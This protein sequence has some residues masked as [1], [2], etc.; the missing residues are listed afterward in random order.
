VAA[1]T[2]DHLSTV[3]SIAVL[4]FMAVRLVTGVRV[5]RSRSGRR[6]VSAVRQRIGWRHLWPVPVVLALVVLVAST[7]MA[8][9]GLDWG[10]W[11]AIGGDGNPVFGSTEQTSGTTWEWLIPLVF[12]ALLLPAL[13]LFANA[14]ERMFRAGAEHWSTSRRVLKTLQFGLVHALIGIPIGAAIALS[15]GGAYFMRVYLR[16]FARTGSAAD[17]TLES[18]TAHTVYNGVI[19]GVVIIAVIVTPI[20]DSLGWS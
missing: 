13:P 6:V 19:I 2:S 3:L 4:G 10:W 17:A 5:S 8:I 15:I 14:E 16:D 12:V 7:L 18:T 1:T 20:L 9:P 11:S